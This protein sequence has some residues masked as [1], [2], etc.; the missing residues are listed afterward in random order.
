MIVLASTPGA[1]SSSAVNR[2]TACFPI[3]R[4]IAR[5]TT[6]RMAAAELRSDRRGV[7]PSRLPHRASW[8]AVSRSVSG[9]LLGTAR[10]VPCIALLLVAHATAAD[11]SVPG[12][13]EVLARLEAGEIAR[14]TE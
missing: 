2:R 10:W 6:W 3:A 14:A 4:T 8:L 1:P 7:S 13:D 12:D 9:R 5:S 11:S